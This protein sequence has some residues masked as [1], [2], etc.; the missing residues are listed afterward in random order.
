MSTLKETEVSLSYVQCFLYLVSSSINVSIFHSTWLVPSGQTSYMLRFLYHSSVSFY[1]VIREK[2]RQQKNDL[3]QY[4]TFYK[5]I[6]ENKIHFDFQVLLH[7][8]L[9]EKN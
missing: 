3:L 8:N 7:K 5:T 6:F 2:Q 4:F 9:K 1:E